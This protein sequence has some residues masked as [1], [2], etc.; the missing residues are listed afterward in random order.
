MGGG[1]Y[2]VSTLRGCGNDGTGRAH[3]APDKRTVC[4]IPAGIALRFLHPQATKFFPGR[5][6]LV[7]TPVSG[8]VDGSVIAHQ[9]APLFS[10]AIRLW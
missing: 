1:R 8:A 4:Q 9:L 7:S 5:C 6:A 3:G 2:G 10:R